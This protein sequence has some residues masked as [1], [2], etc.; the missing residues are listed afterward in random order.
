LQE[1]HKYSFLSETFYHPLMFPQ[2]MASKSTYKDFTVNNPIEVKCQVNL[3]G[4]S[5]NWT[6]DCA[7]LGV[8]MPSASHHLSPV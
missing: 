2:K 7:Q 5:D 1:P 3:S 8:T 4:P 6:L